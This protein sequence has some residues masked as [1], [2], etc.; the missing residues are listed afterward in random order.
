[1]A[2]TL[3]RCTS[4]GRCEG[5]VSR[6]SVPPCPSEE[7]NESLKGHPLADLHTFASFDQ[8][9]AWEGACLPPAELGKYENSIGHQPTGS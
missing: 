6:V 9:R 5:T 1:M 7:L 3:S 8:I 2:S 4:S